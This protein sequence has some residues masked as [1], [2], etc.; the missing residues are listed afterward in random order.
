MIIENP[1]FVCLDCCNEFEHPCKHIAIDAEKKQVECDGAILTCNKCKKST[2]VP[3]VTRKYKVTIECEYS[4]DVSP[5]ENDVVH[6]E[7]DGTDREIL[8][9]IIHDSLSNSVSN[10]QLSKIEKI[11]G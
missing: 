9:S 4:L 2:I 6:S 5:V 8:E 10:F 3:F 1:K 7:Q 11:K